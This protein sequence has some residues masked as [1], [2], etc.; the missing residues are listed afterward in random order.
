M[1]RG[2]QLDPEFQAL[3]KQWKK[4]RAQRRHGGMGKWENKIRTNPYRLSPEELLALRR[5]RFSFPYL[6]ALWLDQYLRLCAYKKKHGHCRVPTTQG[7]LRRWVDTQRR[8]RRAGK[9]S[10]QRQTALNRLHFGWEPLANFRQDAWSR[11]LAELK[12][13]IEHYGHMRVPTRNAS[14]R[15]LAEFLD[16]QRRLYRKGRLDPQR[17]GV[18]EKLGIVWMPRKTAMEESWNRNIAE[19]KRFVEQHGH[20]RVPWRNPSFRRTAQFLDRT[21]KL[22]HRGRLDPKRQQEMEAL[23]VVWSPL[24]DAWNKGLAEL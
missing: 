17:Q 11:G 5:A 14:F 2:A 3:L 20:V 19:L 21:R 18:L 9:V 7:V 13:F 1:K 15:R 10:P 24:E 4:R 12:R 8:R 16:H 23:G 22:Y 6:D